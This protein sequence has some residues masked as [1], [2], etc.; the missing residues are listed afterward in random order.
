MKVLFNAVDSEATGSQRILYPLLALTNHGVESKCLKLSLFDKQIEWADIVVLQCL[1]GDHTYEVIKRC[2]KHNKKVVIDYDDAMDLLPD[3]LCKRLNLSLE[4]TKANWHKYIELADLITT[5]SKKLASYIKTLSDTPVKVLPNLLLST[6]YAKSKDYRPFDKSNDVKILYSCSESHL[7]DFLYIK[8]I[9]KRIGE[10]YSN[11]TII[12]HGLL[13]FTYYCPNYKGKALHINSTP[14]NS[15]YDAIRKHKPHIFIAPL[16]ITPHNVYRSNLKYLQAGLLKCAFVG[17]NLEPYECV[18]NKKS[19][20]LT[21]NRIGWWWH[22][23]KL[24]RDK[25]RIEKLG[26]MAFIDVRKHLLED[27]ILKWKG[28][29]Q[30]VINA[31]QIKRSHKES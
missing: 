7:K 2:H 29:Y 23:R 27:N 11:V 4:K 18:S 16:R 17:T 24:V 9:L 5:P 21:D 8:P 13:N 15:Y 25:S 3:V 31:R 12:S 10:S 19:G 1:I 20:I 22:L 14:Y 6:E 30:E 28:T 26:E